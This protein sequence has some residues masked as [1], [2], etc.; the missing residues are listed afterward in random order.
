MD[1]GPITPALINGLAPILV[2]ALIA[3]LVGAIA[4]VGRAVHGFINANKNV[5]GFEF[6]SQ[7]ATIAVQAAEQ[8]YAD[9]DGDTKK[10]FAIDFLEKALAERNINVDLD[11][12]STAIEAAVMSEFNYPAAVE[13]ASPPAT[14]DVQTSAGEQPETVVTTPVTDVDAGEDVVDEPVDDVV[15]DES[16][17]IT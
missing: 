7:L 12:I 4:F 1:F 17:D 2:D 15:V 11:V 9:Q 13:P 14:T 3:V 8:V 5:K 16:E 6:L 10:R